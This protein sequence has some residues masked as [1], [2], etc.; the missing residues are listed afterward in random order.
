MWKDIDSNN[1]SI[2][3]KGLWIFWHSFP[4]S[5]NEL[6]LSFA[7]DNTSRHEN[8]DLYPAEKYVIVYIRILKRT[9]VGWDR[10]W[11]A[12]WVIMITILFCSKLIICS[13]NYKPLFNTQGQLRLIPTPESSYSFL[14]FCWFPDNILSCREHILLLQLYVAFFS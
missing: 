3:N 9:T 14:N 2:T 6:Y 1:I 8:F 7:F 13:N 11:N 5:L 4:S 12:R 10:S